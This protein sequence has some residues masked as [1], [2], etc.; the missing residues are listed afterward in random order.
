MVVQ[1]RRPRHLASVS[2]TVEQQHDEE[3]AHLHHHNLVLAAGCQEDRVVTVETIQHNL[4]TTHLA[5]HT[6]HLRPGAESSLTALRD[7]P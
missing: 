3:K 2:P 4:H 7:I 6:T 5:E 1:K